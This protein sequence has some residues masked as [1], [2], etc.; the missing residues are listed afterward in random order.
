M[1]F[2]CHFVGAR[3]LL[4]N[5]SVFGLSEQSLYPIHMY[6]DIYI[7]GFEFSINTVYRIHITSAKYPH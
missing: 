7:S 4:I 6:S 3:C 5:F 1:Q 2:N